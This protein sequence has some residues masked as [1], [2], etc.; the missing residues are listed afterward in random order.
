MIYIGLIINQALNYANSRRTLYGH[1]LSNTVHIIFFETPHK[2]QAPS[3][4]KIIAGG[5][6]PDKIVRDFATDS[7]VL[8]DVDRSFAEI[9]PDIGITAFYA[10]PSRVGNVSRSK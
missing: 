7:V 2:G 1:I 4:I 6:S 3:A 8:A 9:G 10:Q 5:N